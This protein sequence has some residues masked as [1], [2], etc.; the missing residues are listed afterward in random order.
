MRWSTEPV[1]ISALVAG[2]LSSVGSLLIDLGAGIDLAT[3]AGKA[4]AGFAIVVGGG[5]LGR[6]QAYSPDT[7]ESLHLDAE[8][9]LDA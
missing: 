8:T 3:A 7:V 5:A 2:L 4:V 9:V 6:S 1:L